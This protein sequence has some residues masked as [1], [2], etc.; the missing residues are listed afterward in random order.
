M[1]RDDFRKYLCPTSGSPDGLEVASALGC[2]ITDAAGNRYLDWLSGISV[3]NVGHRHPEVLRAIR[4]QAEKYLHV[5]VYGE[6]VLEP[7]VA[8]ARALCEIAPMPQPQVFFTSSGAEAIEGA[9]K[10]A[11]KH[12]RRKRFVAFEGSYHGD[13]FGALSITGAAGMRAPFEPLLETGFLPFGWEESLAMIDDRTAAVVVEPIQAEGGVRVP[14]AGF[15][16]KLRS[17]CDETGALL[18]M[19]E[20]QTGLGRTGAMWACEREGV[21]PD[22]LVLAK[23]LGGG[24][25]LGAFVA[26]LPLMFTLSVD[27]PLSHLTT[28][29]GHP[30]SCAAGLA[31]LNVLR[32]Q[33]LARHA[34]ELGTIAM[35]IL[36]GLKRAGEIADARGAGLLLGVELDSTDRAEIV[37][38]ACRH[39][40]LL[41]GTALHDP[42]TIRLVPPLTMTDDELVRGLDI[43]TAAITET[44]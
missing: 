15:L 24:M 38:R 19:D 8:Y 18:I 32:G 3:C 22:I 27:P 40:G 17:R 7:Q 26:G 23:A 36:L 33:D 10:V 6:Y 2:W 4:E 35:N 29:G 39:S 16:K 41:V 13:T 43:F 25:P 44:R 11:R 28:F 14:P 30:V 12:T 9:L 31:A 37:V 20:V 1:I 42:K 5:M 21:K 34:R